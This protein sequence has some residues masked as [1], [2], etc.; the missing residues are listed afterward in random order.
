MD[1]AIHTPTRDTYLAAEFA[2]LEPSELSRLRDELVCPGCG[3]AAYFV[4]RTKKGS[5]FFGARPHNDGCANETT[6]RSSTLRDLPEADQRGLVADAFSLRPH[7]PHADLP[8]VDHD[9]DAPSATGAARRY[10][11]LGGANKKSTPS[12]GLRSLLTK[13]TLDHEY[14]ASLTRINFPDGTNATVAQSCVNVTDTAVT[15]INRRRLYWGTIHKTNTGDDGG[16]WLYTQWNSPNVLLKSD[17][18][19]HVLQDNN[20]EEIDELTGASFIYHGFLNLTRDKTRTYFNP[21]DPNWFT[22]RWF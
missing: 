4:P 3:A 9:P 8:H 6:A 21:R 1:I 19:D 16:A 5:V 13:L 11:L 17:L 12:V 15:H 22:L 7:R 18:L 10:T 20:I 14:A 2:R